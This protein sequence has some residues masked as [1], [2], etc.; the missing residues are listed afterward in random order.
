MAKQNLHKITNYSM[1]KR[2]SPLI[3]MNLVRVVIWSKSE[4]L[5]QGISWKSKNKIHD[6]KH[7]CWAPF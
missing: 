2:G 4:Q 5:L 6:E 1:N 3:L 7:R